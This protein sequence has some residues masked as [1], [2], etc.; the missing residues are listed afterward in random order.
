[1]V[2]LSTDILVSRV[3]KN[4]LLQF[5]QR[6]EPDEYDISAISPIDLLHKWCDEP[7][8]PPPVDRPAS[9]ARPKLDPKS[10]RNRLR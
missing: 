2:W 9:E 3:L 6:Y 1:M 10:N 4:K 8:L 5:S 7:S